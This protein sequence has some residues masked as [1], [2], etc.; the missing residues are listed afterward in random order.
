LVRDLGFGVEVA[1]RSLA[2][3]A[4]LGL[5]WAGQRGGTVPEEVPAP[6]RS[7]SL[8]AKMAVDEIFL[9]LELVSAGFASLRERNRIESEL[10]DALAF[11]ESQGWLER[12]Q[13]FHR[14]P[15]PATHVRQRATSLGR[16]AYRHL[17]FESGYAPHPGE[18]GRARW[19]SYER[20]RT[21]HAWV[22]RHPGRPRPWVVC[23]PGYRMG[24]PAVDLIGF[25]AGRLH[26]RH[27]LN[28][29]IPVLPLHGPRRVGRRGGDGLL[30]GE[31]MDTVH[32]LAQAA[33]DVR[34]LVGWLRGSGAPAVA[35]Q[36]LSL[37]GYTAA[38]VASLE[39]DLDC[40]IAG[41]PAADFVRIVRWHAPALLWR[42]VER[43]GYRLEPVE[44]LLRV[45]SPL[46]MPPRV[47][48]ERRFLFAA[49]A[50][51]LAPPD[52]AR[53]LWRH[54]DRPRMAWYHGS[55]LS[56]RLEREVEELVVGAFESCGLLSAGRVR[57]AC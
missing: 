19:L 31:L 17:S 47:P 49:T 46:A 51:R 16:L 27:G 3:P 53:D 50:D 37:G 23:V 41:I 25:D 55:H 10:R 36:G 20:N 43:L 4:V 24:H 6:P 5:R 12:P 57:R 29:A 54:W 34:R 26:R 39:E 2:V 48:H 33:W 44:R 13:D 7:L 28:V 38:L 56:F 22:L 45:V 32:L 14:T 40:V 30:T 15:P 11:Y 18:P 52:H 21:A 42:V 35:I 9:T 8:T 1:L